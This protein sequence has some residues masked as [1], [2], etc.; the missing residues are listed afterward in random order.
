MAEVLSNHTKKDTNYKTGEQIRHSYNVIVERQYH[1]NVTAND[2]Q[3]R[4]VLHPELF[5]NGIKKELN[6]CPQIIFKRGHKY[7]Y[8]MLKERRNTFFSLFC[9]G[10]AC[11]R[12]EIYLRAGTISQWHFSL[13]AIF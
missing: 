13:I 11:K 1:V 4:Y 6:H 12:C 7:M 10:P 3:S 2:L 8:L 9:T 5:K